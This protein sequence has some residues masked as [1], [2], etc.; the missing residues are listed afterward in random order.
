MGE[1]SF[2]FSSQEGVCYWVEL[3]QA[4]QPWL[5]LPLILYMC[6]NT[7]TECVCNLNLITLCVI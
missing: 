6:Q 1:N 2:R 7:Y 3:E 5:T 4:R